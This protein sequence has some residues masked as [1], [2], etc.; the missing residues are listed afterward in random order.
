MSHRI[1]NLFSVADSM[2]RMTARNSAT[3]EELAET[4]SGRLHAWRRQTG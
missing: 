4:L 3:K 2:V 1:K